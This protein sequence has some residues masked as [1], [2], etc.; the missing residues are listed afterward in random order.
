MRNIVSRSSCPIGMSLDI[1]GDRWSLLV[2]RSMMFA[3]RKT[4]KELLAIDENIATNI[5]SNRLK[6]LEIN[7]IVVKL[8]S[9]RDHR[10][11]MYELTEKGLKLM[12]VLISIIDWGMEY[13]QNPS[14]PNEMVEKT[15]ENQNALI[16]NARRL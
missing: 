11:F 8:S 6:K 10:V 14:L 15:L 7:G 12:P 3:E 9:K 16:N 1:F 13:T 4:F 2:I 5:L